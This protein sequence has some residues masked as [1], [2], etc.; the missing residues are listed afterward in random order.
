MRRPWTVV[1]P[2]EELQSIPEFRRSTS[3]PLPVGKA[4]RSGSRARTASIQTPRDVPSARQ[5][6]FVV[7]RYRQKATHHRQSNLLSFPTLYFVKCGG[8]CLLQTPKCQCL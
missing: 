8:D 3:L 6:P 7:L 2:E 5:L 1:F 4:L